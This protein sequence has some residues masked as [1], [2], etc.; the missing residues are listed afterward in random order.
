MKN[1]RFTLL[2]VLVVCIQGG[3]LCESGLPWH[4]W[5]YWVIILTTCFAAIF[6]KEA[7]TE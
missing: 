2:Y 5:Q 3:V 7:Y 6:F 4:T 1:P